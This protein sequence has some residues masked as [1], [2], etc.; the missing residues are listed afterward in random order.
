MRFQ[1]LADA[2]AAPRLIQQNSRHDDSAEN[3][4]LRI[5]GQENQ[6]HAVLNHRNNKGTNQGAEDPTRPAGQTGAANNDR[7]DDIQFI[8]LCHV[9]CRGSDQSR[10]QTPANPRHDSA[11]H[12]DQ[13]QDGNHRHPRQTRGFLVAADGVDPPAVD[14]S[15]EHESAEEENYDEEDE[16]HW[17]RAETL[18]P[19]GIAPSTGSFTRTINDG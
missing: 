11:D 6:I 19:D 13:N 7:R 10:L 17:N 5:T 2:A 14:G 16:R 9:R 12:I 3:E 8:H 15:P 4:S 18:A 1:Q